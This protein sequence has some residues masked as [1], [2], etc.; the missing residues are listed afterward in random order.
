MEPRVND[1]FTLDETEPI[2]TTDVAEGQPQTRRLVW[3]RRLCLFTGLL[4]TLILV[5]NRC[6]AFVCGEAVLEQLL[7]NTPLLTANNSD[8]SNRK[9]G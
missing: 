4:V 2:V 6:P 1:P 8:G 9:E 3:F 5:A 7:Q